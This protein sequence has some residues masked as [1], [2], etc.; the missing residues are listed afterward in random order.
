MKVQVN[1]EMVYGVDLGVRHCMTST[2]YVG[3][4]MVV[5][6]RRG[7]GGGGVC[8][9]RLRHPTNMEMVVARTWK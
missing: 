6:V 4:G 9:D 8:I 3:A 5:G 1:M 2:S 7:W